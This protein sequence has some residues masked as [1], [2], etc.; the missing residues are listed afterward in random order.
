M[1]TCNFCNGKLEETDQ[2]GTEECELC[3]TTYSMLP[4]KR[5]DNDESNK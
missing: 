5:S 3:G 1:R 4:M 2:Y